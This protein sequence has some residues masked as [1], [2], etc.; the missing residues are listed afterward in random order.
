MSADPFED[1]VLRPTPADAGASRDDSGEAESR[2][3]VRS[4]S[5]REAL[6]TVGAAGAAAMVPASLAPGRAE[7]PTPSGMGTEVA[8]APPGS[9]AAAPAPLVNLTAAETEILAAMVDRLIPTDEL[10]PGALDAGV[11]TYIDRALGESDPEAVDAYR[12][13]LAALDRYS[14]YSRDG[15]F[16]DLEGRDQ[17]SVLIDVQTGAATGAGVGFQGSSAAFFNLVK[18]H[19]WQGMF[20]DPRYGANLGFA[21]WDLIRYPGARL[22]VTDDEQRELERGALPPVRRSAY[23]FG[24]FRSGRGG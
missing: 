4:I 1:R 7:P 3:P 14:R 18:G 22:R 9:A 17:D 13:G 6:K 23:E 19:V 16:V 2:E 20:G 5:R 8:S 10:G 11:L 21:G 12:A 15:A 24:L